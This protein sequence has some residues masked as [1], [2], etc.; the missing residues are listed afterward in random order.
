[1]I[2]GLD[3]DR[4][5]KAIIYLMNF[6]ENSFLFFDSWIERKG[7]IPIYVNAIENDISRVVNRGKR[8]VGARKIILVGL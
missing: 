1:L 5:P 3:P 2:E 4:Y 8:E 6:C 7:W